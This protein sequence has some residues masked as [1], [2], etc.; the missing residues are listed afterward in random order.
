M[1]NYVWY[2]SYGSNI[3]KERFYKYLIGGKVEGA[4]IEEIG[5][6]DKTLPIKTKNILLRHKLF[7]AGESKRWDGGVAFINPNFNAREKTFSKMYLIKFEQFKD[8][9]CQENSLPF[10]EPI[11][12]GV[13]GLTKNHSIIIS[14]TKY[15]KVLCLGEEDG[16]PIFTFTT[17]KEMSEMMLNKP[18]KEYIEI[19]SKGI[20]DAFD[21]DK[22]DIEKYFGLS[23]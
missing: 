2:A 20:I 15:G 1:Y 5:S 6:R 12:E 9:F 10:D 23:K 11:W 14:N 8:V 7:F 16:Y 13:S 19:I 4:K 18:S 22:Y 21:L 17:T 3:N